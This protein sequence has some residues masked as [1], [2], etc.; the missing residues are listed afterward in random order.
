[1]EL[2]LH[3]TDLQD[4]RG[5]T[6]C[7]GC[8]A[9][10]G[11][12]LLTILAAMSISSLSPNQYGIMR[13]YFSGNVDSQVKRGGIFFAGPFT[14]VIT[15]PATQVTLDF[16]QQSPDRGPVTSRTG[17]DPSDPDS[18][19]QPISISCAI[20]FKF[21]PSRLREVYLAF[22]TF[23]GARQ[24]YLL[25]AGNMVSNT[26]Q[27]F[28]PQ[29]FWQERSHITDRMLQRVNQTLFSNGYVAAVRFQLTRIDFGQSFEDSI[30]AVQVAEQ[31]RVLNEYEQQV[32][33]VAQ[34][35][36]VLEAGNE[37]LIANISS[38]AQA[39][40]K[41]IVA[42]AKRDAFN[43]QQQM[44]ATR[45]KELQSELQFSPADMREYFKIKSVQGQGQHGKVVIGMPSVGNAK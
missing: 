9:C 4:R 27:E 19:G 23:E 43:L 28:T 33:Q 6:L 18:G 24:R 44:K 5:L 31:Q 14:G 40:S 36:A 39:R 10:G 35:M 15:Y 32:Q 1:M 17:A 13:S 2:P 25:L 45:Y 21:E 3:A 12:I 34:N 7:C 29:Q 41:E 22:S 26:A 38:G 42:G 8:G 20:Q 30:T 16:S 37:A 11:G